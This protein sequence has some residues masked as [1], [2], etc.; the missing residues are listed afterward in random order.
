MRVYIDALARELRMAK[1]LSRGTTARM[2][3]IEILGSA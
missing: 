1:L 2:D 3:H